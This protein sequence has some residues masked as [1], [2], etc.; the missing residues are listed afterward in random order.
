MFC[1]YS[2]LMFRG[3]QIVF[4][5]CSQFLLGGDREVQAF[6]SLELSQLLCL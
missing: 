4:W 6:G 2:L 5:L 1:A 3:V